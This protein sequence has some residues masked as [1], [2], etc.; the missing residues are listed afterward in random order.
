MSS[1]RIHLYFHD[2]QVMEAIGK[3]PSK[4]K[5]A[6]IEKCILYYLSHA[7]TTSLP[8]SSISMDALR[9]EIKNVLYSEL[10]FLQKDL[11]DIQVLVSKQKKQEKLRQEQIDLKI[12]HLNSQ[13]DQL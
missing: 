6:F 12:K 1:S 8:E 10:S 3:I 7:S 11:S 5:S 13:L 4:Q 2:S 9:N